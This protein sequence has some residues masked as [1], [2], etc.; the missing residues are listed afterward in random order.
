MTWVRESCLFFYDAFDDIVRV[1]ADRR[2]HILSIRGCFIWAANQIL[3]LN[4]MEKWCDDLE[5][6]L[7]KTISCIS[8][9][10]FLQAI[11]KGDT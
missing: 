5:V 3:I 11:E 10:A 6:T 7:Y 1:C 4:P 9:A 2:I 8:C